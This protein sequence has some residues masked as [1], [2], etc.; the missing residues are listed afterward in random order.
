[1]NITTKQLW[2]TINEG[3]EGYRPDAAR[4]AA[5]VVAKVAAVTD[6]RM[7]KDERGNLIPAAK[8]A[9]RLARDLDRLPS[10]TNQSA[11]DIT[12]AAI[13]FARAQLAG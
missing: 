2:D 11:R 8:L 4:R 1:M 5:P 9:A 3:G 10:L 6:S 12:Q 13:D 7:L